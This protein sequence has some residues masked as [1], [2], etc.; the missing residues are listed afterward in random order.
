MNEYMK[1]M[2]ALAEQLAAQGVTRSTFAPPAYQIAWRLGLR[3]RPPLYQPFSTLA[4]GMG[5]GFGVLWG[6]MM[7]IFFWRADGLPALPAIGS[8]LLGGALFGLL[9]AAYYRSRAAR[10][11]LPLLDQAS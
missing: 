3:V 9:M 8:A 6:L 1:R 2:Q 5:T 4:L 11:R 7:W 10:L